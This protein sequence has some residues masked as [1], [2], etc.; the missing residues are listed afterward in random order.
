VSVVPQHAALAQALTHSRE[1]TSSSSS[2]GASEGVHYHHVLVQS[3]LQQQLAIAGR[4]SYIRVWLLVTSINPLRAYLFNGGF[5][6]FGK[7]KG[8]SSPAAGAPSKADSSS[9]DDLIVNLWIQDRNS[10]PIWS[11]QQLQKHL[12]AH[13]DIV[14]PSSVGGDQQQPQPQQPSKAGRR[15][16]HASNGSSSTTAGSGSQQRRRTFA[17]AWRDMQAS[18]SLVLAAALPAM[19]AAASEVGAPQQGAFEYFGLDFVLDAQLRPWMLEVNAIPSMAR[20]KKSDCA[21]ETATANCR[22]RTG[23]APAAGGQPGNSSNTVNDD[24]D[25]QKE[26]FVHDML[27]LLGLP[28]DAPSNSGSIR[29]GAVASTASGVSGLK[30]CAS[31]LHAAAAAAA[32]AGIHSPASSSSNDSSSS[33]SSSNNSSSQHHSRAAAGRRLRSKRLLQQQ[34]GA[35]KQQQ[36][37]DLPGLRWSGPAPA[38]SVLPPQLQKLLCQPGSGSASVSPGFACVACLTADD[39]VALAI[40]E[41]ELQQAGRF[42]AVHDLIA[43]HK[44]NAAA[45]RAAASVAAANSSSSGAVDGSLP[46][47][48]AVDK[49]ADILMPH[50]RGGPG[51]LSDGRTIWQKL[52]TAWRQGMSSQSRLQHQGQDSSPVMQ[53]YTAASQVA[54]ER[55]LRLQRLDYVMSAWLRARRDVPCDGGGGDLQQ[56]AV[57]VAARLTRLVSYCYDG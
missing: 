53:W 12:D 34:G 48:A 29:R 10:S 7:Q 3:Y 41:Q 44:L 40:A 1:P 14:Q 46:A 27:L 32:A 47:A 51:I 5:A 19:R 17:D 16:L 23:G 11:L 33:S 20:R 35:P 25:E 30:D 50:S 38:V 56:P 22:L 42:V 2:D 49:A 6:I 18:A 28:V 36:R 21:G 54:A 45:M 57:C 37:L 43:A 24:F 55:R 52:H 15:H 31:V 26:R 13:P 39:L 9:G 4:S 8:S